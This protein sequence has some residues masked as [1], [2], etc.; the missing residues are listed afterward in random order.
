MLRPFR[1]AILWAL[2][3]L[4]LCLMPGKAL[5]TWRW[6]DLL[7]VDKAVHAGLFAV[8]LVLVAR[9]ISV[10]SGA[11]GMSVPGLRPVLACVA[12]GASVE[13]LQMLSA[14]GRRGDWNDVMANTAGV[15]AAWAWLR[16]S[17]GR[18]RRVPDAAHA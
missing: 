16:W 6:A 18:Q 1:W 11:P 8:Q 5:P 10:R 17:A 14:L 2:L 7:S 3:I 12:Y 9:G 13:A 15:A 4:V